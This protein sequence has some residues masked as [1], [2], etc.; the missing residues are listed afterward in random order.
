[1]KNALL[2]G[3][4]ALTL[5][6]NA[7][8]TPGTVTGAILFGTGA[9]ISCDHLVRSH[10]EATPES[11]EPWYLV[12]HHVG[13]EDVAGFAAGTACAIPAA[14]AGAAVG[15]VVETTVV[16]TSVTAVGAG[17]VVVAGKGLHLAS[18]AVA[19]PTK[20]ATAHVHAAMQRTSQWL[21]QIKI[22]AVKPS[23]P[24]RSK[25]ME[26]L[27]AKQKGRDALCNVPLP[28]LYVGTWWNRSLNREIE[29]DHRKPR[30]KGGTDR[31]SNLQLTHSSFNRAKRDLTGHEVRRAKLR[32]CP[33]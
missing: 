22:G 5:I 19:E 8:A 21:G 33:L 26:S 23:T 3:L 30:A 28:P 10:M 31:P 18:R 9:S 12:W 14:V 2:G 16:G 25:Y 15:L 1:M 6:P 13:T 27:Y 20:R 4:A 7:N 11:D 17:A 29:V 32:F 24:L